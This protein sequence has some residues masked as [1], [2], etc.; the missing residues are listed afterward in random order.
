[1]NSFKKFFILI[2]VSFMVSGL[3][4]QGALWHAARRM[5][6]VTRQ[7]SVLG[8]TLVARRRHASGHGRWQDEVER[9]IAD[10]RRI[11][12]ETRPATVCPQPEERAKRDD[13][14]RE[15]DL[16]TK[17]AELDMLH[18]R[19]LED[20][21]FRRGLAAV[22]VGACV[23][24]E[25]IMELSDCAFESGFL[26]GTF[27]GLPLDLLCGFSAL[28]CVGSGVGVVGTTWGMKKRQQRMTWLGQQIKLPQQQK[29]DNGQQ[30][31]AGQ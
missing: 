26:M 28:A 30:D 23:V 12:A 1:M 29:V 11:L 8:R 15:E 31:E 16:R 7:A 19:Q 13:V 22:A 5:L 4:A 27:I 14:A 18:G 20:R 2:V 3:Q 24:T 21:L 25:P 9:N 6:V 17:R 10:S